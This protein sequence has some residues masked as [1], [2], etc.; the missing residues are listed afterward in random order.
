MRFL[1]G[2]LSRA[3]RMMAL[4]QEI[5]DAKVLAGRLLAHQLRQ[6]AA[7]ELRDAE[8]RVF[9]Q[10]GDDGLIQYLVHRVGIRHE[11]RRFIEFGVEDYAEANTRFLLVNDDWRGLVMD[12]SARNMRR[13]QDGP[14]YWR[15]DLTARAAFIDAA[16][17]DRLI[18]EAGFGG[19]TGLLSIDLDGNDYWVWERIECTRP[20]IVIVEYNSVFGAEQAVS[21]PYDPAFRRD[22]AHYSHLYWGCSIAAL[23]ALGARKGYALVGS[24]GAGNNAYFVRRDRLAGLREL[25]PKEAYVESRFRESRDRSGGLSYLS[26]AARLQAIRELPLEVVDAGRRATIAELYGL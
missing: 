4:P 20:V 13:L 11:E 9:S 24:N 17:I 7:L 2:A 25:R 22:A 10:F 18:A 19:D 5:A 8:F 12:A 14:L 3:R 6:S 23:A 16:N 1:R 26:G 21:I 15:H